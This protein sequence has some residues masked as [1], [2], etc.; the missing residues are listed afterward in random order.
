MNVFDCHANNSRLKSVH[1]GEKAAL[2]LVL[3]FLTLAFSQNHVSVAVMVLVS[4]LLLWLCRIPW[5][6]YRRLLLLPLAF[7][8]P[9]CLA[10]AVET[11][12]ASA[13]FSATV[14][15]VT[16]GI[17]A[18]GMETALNILLRSL[19][20]VST[21]YFL[22]LTTPFN[23]L[24]WLLGRLK[25]PGP[26]VEL[27]AL[28]Y[29]FIFVLSDTAAAIFTSQSARLG[30]GSVKTSFHSLGSLSAALLIKTYHRS[31]LLDQSLSSRCYDGEFRTLAL[32][33]PVSTLNRSIIAAAALLLIVTAYFPLLNHVILC[34]F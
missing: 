22:A 31:K 24:A 27:A 25:I 9:G 10:V 32:C 28:I 6:L 7:L 8:L 4:I 5:L 33:F 16:L 20:S 29:R 19:A 11:A 26:A 21:L 13:L 3:L 12:P 14:F 15:K 34:N 30:Y 23:D 17:T 2:S 1:P 18:P